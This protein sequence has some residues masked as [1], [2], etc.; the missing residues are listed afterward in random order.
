MSPIP[1]GSILLIGMDEQ[2]IIVNFIVGF[3]RHI[4]IYDEKNTL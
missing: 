3:D 4:F 2:Y 1:E